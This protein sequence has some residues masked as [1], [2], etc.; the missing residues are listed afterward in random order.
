MKV[1]TEEYLTILEVV[2]T[3]W[4]E[5]HFYLNKAMLVQDSTLALASRRVQDFLNRKIPLFVP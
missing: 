1:D 4:L 2:L 3:P 5:E